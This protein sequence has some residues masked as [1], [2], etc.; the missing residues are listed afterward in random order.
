MIFVLLGELLEFKVTALQKVRH[1][2]SLIAT[3]KGITIANDCK[4]FYN[5]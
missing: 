1:R 4:L 3:L 5:L 2:S